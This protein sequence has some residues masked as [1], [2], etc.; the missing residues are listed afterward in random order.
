MTALCDGRGEKFTI[1]SQ[2][3]I[4]IYIYNCITCKIV[5]CGRYYDCGKRVNA[6]LQKEELVQVLKYSTKY[7][8]LQDHVKTFLKQEG[9]DN[10]D[11][12]VV[13]T[14]AERGMQ[15]YFHASP[16]AREGFNSNPE[17]VIRMLSNDP[18]IC[19][20][21]KFTDDDEDLNDT[22]DYTPAKQ[23]VSKPSGT[24]EELQKQKDKKVLWGIIFLILFWPVGVYNLYKAYQ[25]SKEI[26]KL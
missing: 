18:N 6:M 25:I 16:A 10:S 13:D 23:Y 15:L 26:E 24:K 3:H 11:E 14:I 22:S 17:G 2:L 20:K 8:R 9:K 19:W 7:Y 4:Y 5:G 1:Y 21:L 12:A